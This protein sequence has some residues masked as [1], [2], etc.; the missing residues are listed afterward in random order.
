[1]LSDSV[2]DELL[3]LVELLAVNGP[4]LG[5]PHAD[6]LA[7]SKHANMKEL[8]FTADDGV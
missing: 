5:R 2:Q 7:R 6:T 1:M 8:R 3:A 4:T